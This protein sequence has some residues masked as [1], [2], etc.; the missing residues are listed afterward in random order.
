MPT[1]AS[2]H[3]NW[4]P[5][6]LASARCC[7]ITMTNMTPSLA[8]RIL[9]LLGVADKRLWA[10][11]EDDLCFDPR[12]LFVMWNFQ[13]WDLLQENQKVF[14][15]EVNKRRINFPKEL[16]FGGK[17][18]E[19]GKCRDCL[20]PSEWVSVVGMKLP[21]TAGVIKRLEQGRGC[22]ST[23]WKTQ[24]AWANCW[25]K[26]GEDQDVKEWGSKRMRGT[27]QGCLPRCVTWASPWGCAFRRALCAWFNALS[28]NSLYFYNKE[29][30]VSFGFGPW[31]LYSQSWS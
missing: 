12:T 7:G 15:E 20:G 6:T 22:D 26:K 25:H 5:T 29:P 30:E 3:V 16:N 28:W 4:A 14:P 10:K 8:S 23:T 17:S 24:E 9:S 31:K 13:V 1:A 18:M 19:T 2:T 27:R 21:R 11:A